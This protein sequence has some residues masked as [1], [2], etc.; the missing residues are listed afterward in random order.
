MIINLTPHDICI[1]D[2]NGEVLREYRS[3][4]VVRLNTYVQACEPIEGVRTTKVKFGELLGLPQYVG[5]TYYIVSRLVKQA[6][7]DR[8]DL[9]VP[10]E[11]VRDDKGLIIGCKSLSIN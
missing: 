10:N 5:G 9:L 3:K 11:I 2:N 6:R 8:C 4:G 7:P 1:L